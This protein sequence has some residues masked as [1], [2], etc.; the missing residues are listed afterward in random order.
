MKRAFP[1]L[2]LI[3]A[4]LVSKNPPACGDNTTKTNLSGKITDKK[5]GQPIP[6]ATVYLPDFQSGAM[7]DSPGYY[8]IDN[9]YPA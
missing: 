7:S 2:F 5:T 3:I 8:F 1:F 4:L 6:G 9:L